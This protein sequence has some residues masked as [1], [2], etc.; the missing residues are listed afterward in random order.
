MARGLL[1]VGAIVDV[2]LA[3]LIVSI[4]GFIVGSGPESMRAGPWGGAVLIAIVLACLAAP[5]VGF[6]MERARR[7]A[8]GILVAWLPPMI[9]LIA[10]MIPPGY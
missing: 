5:V 2:G 8:G 1:I 7:P 3:V 9:G 10:L 6:A 4:S